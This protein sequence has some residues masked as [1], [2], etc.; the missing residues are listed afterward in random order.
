M[1]YYIDMLTY[2]SGSY[3]QYAEYFTSYAL[4]HIEYYELIKQSRGIRYYRCQ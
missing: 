1:T 2:V 4:Q 3:A